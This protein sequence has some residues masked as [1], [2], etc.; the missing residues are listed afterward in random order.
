MLHGHVF[1]PHLLRLVLG[2][3]QNIV[4]IL[5]HVYLRSGHLYPG[6]KPAL[7]V[8]GKVLLLYLHLLD[9]LRNQTVFLAQQR[10]K[11]MFL[12]QLLIA[13]LIGKLFTIVN[14]F[15]RFLCKLLNVHNHTSSFCLFAYN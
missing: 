12:L 3:N 10:R 5:S 8:V 4:Q 14:R 1:V 9:Q 7:R 6:G 2:M 15:D 11:Q 13:V